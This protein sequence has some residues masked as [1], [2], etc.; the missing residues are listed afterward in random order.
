MTEKPRGTLIDNDK[1][2]LKGTLIERARRKSGA[3]SKTGARIEVGVRLIQRDGRKVFEIADIKDTKHG[4][5]VNLRSLSGNTKFTLNKKILEEKLNTE[6][7]EWEWE[8]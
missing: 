7:S 6:G 1:T 4:E 5:V 2:N 8:F 3:E